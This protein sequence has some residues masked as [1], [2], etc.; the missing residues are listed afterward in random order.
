MFSL[1]SCAQELQA[2]S[3]AFVLLM[4]ITILEDFNVSSGEAVSVSY[5]CHI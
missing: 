5:F 3:E 1:V 2:G 4:G